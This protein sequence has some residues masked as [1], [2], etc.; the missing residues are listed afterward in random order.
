MNVDLK[1][2]TSSRLE[3][4]HVENKVTLKEYLQINSIRYLSIDKFDS[5]LIKQFEDI[6]TS[7]VMFLS[8]GA[9]WIIKKDQ[10]NNFFKGNIFNI[11]GTRLPFYR[12][13][14]AISWQILNQDRFGYCQLHHIDGGIDTGNIVASKEFI[15]PATCRVP[16]DFR[17]I[18]IE[19]NKNFI[20]N[21][22]NKIFDKGLVSLNLTQPNY[23]SAYWP[24][25]SSDI[26]GW[27]DWS[28]NGYEIERLICAFD[29]P[30]SGA[31]TYIGGKKVHLK[32][33]SVC[34]GDPSTHS[35]QAGLIYRKGSG[36]ICVAAKKIN[37]LIELVVVDGLNILD[38]LSLGDRFFTPPDILSLSKDRITYGPNGL[39]KK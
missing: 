31:Q 22:L 20:I 2:I 12:G 36:F 16:L 11:H 13:G 37:L 28:L 19:E 23:L 18:Y 6:E 4:I 27:V 14:A 34:G 25:L 30:Y 8:M 35:F 29:E 33:V 3:T 17:A 10:I 5:E 15:Y 32:K 26:N 7:S 24:R 1:V 38:Q 39:V 21:C 9:P